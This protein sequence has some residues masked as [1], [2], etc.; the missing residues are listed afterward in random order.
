[1]SNIYFYLSSGYFGSASELSPLTHTWSL[2]VEEQFY[3]FFPLLAVLVLKFCARYFVFI[4]ILL[5][6]ASL[7]L[8]QFTSKNS[9]EWAF[10][11]LPTRAWELL[12]GSLGALIIGKRFIQDIGNVTK[13]YLAFI[14]LF[15]II[16]SYFVFTPSTN[17]PSLIT[18][19]PVIGVLM[20]ILFSSPQ[21]FIGQL[22]SLRPLVHVGLISYSLY[23]W[24]QPVLAIAKL[25]ISL[26]LDKITVLMFVSLNLHSQPGLL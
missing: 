16:A 5:I 23:L 18:A 22:L 21:Q 14:G 1:M 15:L 11:L 9:P 10:Y 26:H 20:V 3:V 12:L 19:V 17:H 13:A 25:N 8:A 2:S 24:H 7:S 4:L 6:V